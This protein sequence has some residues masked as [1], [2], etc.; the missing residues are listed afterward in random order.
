MAHKKDTKKRR[1]RFVRDGNPKKMRMTQRSI[2]VLIK[3]LHMVVLCRDQIC[4]LG[5]S[6]G[7]RINSSCNRQMRLLF[8]SERISR[9]PQYTEDLH[10]NRPY[11]YS[12]DLKGVASLA[13]HFG[14]QKGDLRWRKNQRT[15]YTLL[16]DHDVNDVW[17]SF[18][19]GWQ[20]LGYLSLTW[21]SER[22][23]RRQQLLE[24]V[25]VERQGESY[26]YTV[27][28]DGVALFR[29]SLRRAF[30]IEV[31]RGSESKSQLKKK[32]AG[33]CEYI[34]TKSFQEKFDVDDMRV[35][36]VVPGQKRL[37]EITLIIEEITKEMNVSPSHFALSLFELVTPENAATRRIWA[38]PGIRK[39]MA[40][41]PKDQTMFQEKKLAEKPRHEVPMDEAQEAFT[42]RW[43][44]LFRSDC[45]F[46]TAS[47]DADEDA[48]SQ[49]EP[50][51]EPWYT[52]IAAPR[53]D[54]MI[55]IIYQYVDDK[56]ALR[57]SRRLTEVEMETFNATMYPFHDIAKFRRTK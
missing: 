28:P 26:P 36:F 6:W 55:L 22:E 24:S 51:D 53:R 3:L 34:R 12:L 29:N 18:E 11:L 19:Q 13:K 7:N 2:F 17:I 52:L 23:L 14:S 4:R 44:L 8:D 40:L 37:N 21:I 33:Y 45:E 15:S 16:H 43:Q 25:K 31:D 1:K 27:I 9:Q 54:T 46:T 50:I 10:D 57:A 38:V 35:L 30:F 47:V 56:I 32:I 49:P 48:R 5:F 41:L 39:Y 42:K 20:L